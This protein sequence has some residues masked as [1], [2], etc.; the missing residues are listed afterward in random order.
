MPSELGAYLQRHR[1]EAGMTLEDVERASHIRLRHLVALENGDWDALPPSVYLRGIL[2][3]YARAVKISP[4]GVLRM[5]VK[6]RPNESRLPE[7]QLI[8]QPLLAEPRISREFLTAL[9]LFLV[10]GALLAWV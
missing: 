6:E 10:A 4:A 3:N 8:N 7:P 1:E 5:Y 2:R 9:G